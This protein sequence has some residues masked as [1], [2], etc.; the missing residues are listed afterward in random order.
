[1]TPFLRQPGFLSGVG[2]TLGFPPTPHDVV[3]GSGTLTISAWSLEYPPR[4]LPATSEQSFNY[5]PQ[6]NPG[7]RAI[8]RRSRVRRQKWP[9]EQQCPLR[10]VR[11]GLRE[12]VR[13]VAS[14][15]R[16]PPAWCCGHKYSLLEKIVSSHPLSSM[17]VLH[18]PTL[19]GS[20]RPLQASCSCRPGKG[21]L[22]RP[23]PIGPPQ[24]FVQD[25]PLR[26]PRA[27]TTHDG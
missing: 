4:M 22:A 15:W 1:M 24:L 12:F 21:G 27:S 23:P 16:V 13:P 8:E 26:H 7:E 18:P 17:N 25:T 19:C 10:R 20:G 6:Q 14:A 9:L 3:G 5:N 11:R 2:E